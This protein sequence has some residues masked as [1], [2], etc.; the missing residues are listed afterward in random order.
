M[1]TAYVK[2]GGTLLYSTCTV[3]K[4]ENEDNRTYF[5]EAH[6]DFKADSIT[7]YLPECL[8]TDTAADGYTTLLTGIP[9]GMPLMDGFFI[10]R[11]VR[12]Y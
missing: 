12:M 5:L 11:F 9:E 10:A 8:Q 2:R 3:T 6:S 4:E 7:P 1:A